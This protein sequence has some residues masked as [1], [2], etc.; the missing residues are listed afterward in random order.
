MKEIRERYLFILASALLYVLALVIPN[1]KV[2]LAVSVLVA[3]IAF[4]KPKEGLLSLLIYFPTRYFLTEINPG[5]KLAGDIIII[6][7]FIRILW[8]QRTNW[9]QI[10]AF[11]IFEWGFF[12]F[13]IIGT[14]SA[15][16]TGVSPSAIVFQLRAFIITY[17]LFY[18]VRRLNISKEDVKQFL[19][20]TFV[21]AMIITL[22]GLVE[23]LSSRSFLLPEM[24][25]GRMLSP[26]N[27]SRIYGLTNNPNVLAVYLSI[28]FLCTLY[29]QQF[30]QKKGMKL[31]LTISMI[32]M[33]GV[34]TLTYSRGTWIGFAVALAVYILLTRN[35]G[36]L[37]RTILIL[38]ASTILI[39]LPVVEATKWI[40]ANGI[41]T[42]APPSPSDNGDNEGEDTESVE[43]KRIEG[44]F[45][46]STLEL[47]K[48]TGRL[49]IVFKGFEI[50]K[51][52]P[53]IGT[54][55]G[56]YGDSATKS[57]SSPI[58]DDYDIGFDIYSDNQYI[59]IIVQTGALGVIA[60]A[61]FLLGMLLGLWKYRKSSVMA[62][63]TLALLLGIYWCGF[64]YNI[65]EDKTFTLY[66]F[67]MIGFIFNLLSNKERNRNESTT[68]H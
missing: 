60:F 36:V 48:E 29:L 25:A 28:A 12:A 39:N 1:A 45:D 42:P 57:Y 64:I 68:S 34:W 26:N 55:F 4:F 8:D 31:F 11:T 23:K 9:K 49:F 65:W 5:L 53:V 19:W 18:I 59:Q 35:W 32:F 44:T 38:L 16:L 41:F 27:A 63:P 56:T 61:V 3:I 66:F 37:K 6:A 2:G 21:M 20:I 40:K 14:I 17:L 7:A 47:S 10:F 13:L 33:M 54:G 58:Y 52:H 24:W 43:R 62:I 46:E 22:H 30:I 15:F 50:F 67:I 51:D